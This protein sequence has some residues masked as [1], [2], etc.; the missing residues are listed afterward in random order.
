MC[1]AVPSKSI[2]S[3]TKFLLKLQP[4]GIERLSTTNFEFGCPSVLV[5]ICK[6]S[7]FLR[8]VRLKMEFASGDVLR[9]IGQSSP[10]IESVI[11]VIR[12]IKLHE[13][14]AAKVVEILGKEGLEGN[15]YKGF[16]GGWAKNDVKQKIQKGK[17]IHLSFPKL[18]Y[19]DVGDS[20]EMRDFLHHLLYVYS[21][22]CSI[23]CNE[24]DRL[25]R[26]HYGH[27]PGF[28]ASMLGDVPVHLQ[29][30]VTSY[31]LQD[32]SFSSYCLASKLHNIIKRYKE[33]G[34]HNFDFV[35]RSMED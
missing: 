19:I 32:M 5:T 33:T 35:Q 10:N 16:F 21:D 6:H 9:G 17:G 18:K 25:M 1:S 27:Y 26:M 29:G 3:L 13:M 22:I 7:P 12:K 31:N 30:K 20:P 15:L 11:I 4:F 34:A 14:K 24:E 2:S 8:W 23:T 28:M